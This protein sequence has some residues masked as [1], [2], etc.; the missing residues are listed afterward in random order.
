MK[1]GITGATGHFGSEVLR[2]LAEKVNQSE[3]IALA[4]TPKQATL[5]NELG[6][7]VRPAD[8]DDFDTLVNSFKG[9]DRL[10]IVSTMEPNDQKRF[11]QHKT[12]IDAAVANQVKLIIYISAAGAENSPLGGAHLATE[13]YL[14]KV[15][16]PYIIQRNN[17]YLET[18]ERDFQQAI[19]TGNLTTSTG[20]GKMGLVLRT[21]YAEATANMLSGKYPINQTVTLSANLVN[22]DELAA[23]LSAKLGR[24]ITVHHI[25]DEQ[26]HAGLIKAKINPTMADILVE[27]NRAIRNG[28][29]NIQADDLEIILGR[30]A[31]PVRQALDVLL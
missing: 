11:I 25:S 23:D 4:R 21:E 18:K 1:I 5:A 8:F 10:A 3:I 27:N 13:N 20:V 24:Q 29:A 9:I 22:Y 31:T 2:Y 17:T 16:T 26:Y 30:K 14:K 12:A 28:N 6:V 19:A 15:G 7:E